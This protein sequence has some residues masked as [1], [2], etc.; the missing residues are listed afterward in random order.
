MTLGSVAMRRAVGVRL[1]VRRAT[2]DD[3]PAIEELLAALG[4]R[5]GVVGALVASLRATLERP[6]LALFLA[7]DL[8]TG[9]PV[10]L[11]LVSQRPQLQLGGTLVSIDT[12]VVSPESRGLGVGR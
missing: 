9:R 10:G 11:L 12:L 6:D 2:E 7:C 4:Y 1:R 3:L 5:V 8:A